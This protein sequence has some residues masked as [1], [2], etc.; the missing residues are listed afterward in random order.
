MTDD[1]AVKVVSTFLPP[2]DGRGLQDIIHDIAQA[3][4]G[5]TLPDLDVPPVDKDRQTTELRELRK[6]EGRPL[7]SRV[8]QR[9]TRV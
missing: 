6:S 9:H 5:Q 1:S 2:N 7:V 4:R 8:Q 3:E